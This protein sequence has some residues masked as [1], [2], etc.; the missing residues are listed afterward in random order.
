MKMQRTLILALI[1]SHISGISLLAQDRQ[2]ARTYQST[3]LPK[4][5]FD[6]E[7]WNTFRTGREYLYTRFDQ[8]LEFEYGVTDRFQNAFYFNASHKGQGSTDTAFSGFTRSSSFSFSHEMKWKLLDPAVDRI[9]FGLYAEYTVASHELELEGKILLDKKTEKNIFAFNAVGE[10]VYEWTI[11][12]GEVE[13]ENE[14]EWENDLAYMYMFKPGFGLGLEIRDHNEFVDGEMEHAALFGGPTLFW[15]SGK[16][17]LILNILPQLM[18]LKASHHS[19][20]LDLEEHERIEI[21]LLI[22][23][24]N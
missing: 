15:S 2:F 23:F 20:G 1:V 3:V 8:R 13:I 12:K 10:Y 21:R 18:N 17:F 5:A 9:G 14:I 7:F 19:G 6:I 11:D 24:G 22:G 16:Q 4:G